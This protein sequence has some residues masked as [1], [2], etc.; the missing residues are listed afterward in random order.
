MHCRCLMGEMAVV[1]TVSLIGALGAEQ[2]P[3]MAQAQ[4][5]KPLSP[6]TW[7]SFTGDQFR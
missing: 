5:G 2:R 4:G 6:T 7:K 1:A 3:A